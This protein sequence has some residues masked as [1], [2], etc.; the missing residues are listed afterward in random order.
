MTRLSR[1]DARCKIVD[2]IGE[3]VCH[4]LVLRESLKDER[5][6]LES[7]DTEALNDAVTAK[8]DCVSKLA[9]LEQ[10]RAELCE[11]LGF[12]DG[13]EQM[14]RMSE[15]CDED[16]VVASGWLQLLEI[17]TECNSLNLTNGAI[18]S[19]RRQHTDSQLAVLRGTDSQTET[20]GREGIDTAAR[21]RRALAQA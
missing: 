12:H 10:Q 3:S 20:Y 5:A 15:W 21:N 16:S 11:R 1:A 2:V 14:T 13:P 9:E 19:L 6:A 4:A 7:Q 18:I 17:A 8:S